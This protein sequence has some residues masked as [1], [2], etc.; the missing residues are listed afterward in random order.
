MH[1]LALTRG[2]R[3]HHPR[4]MSLQLPGIPTLASAS[5]TQLE[6]DE[7]GMAYEVLGMMGYDNKRLDVVITAVPERGVSLHVAL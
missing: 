2:H 6:V 4:S 7:D 3:Y 1:K 5:Y